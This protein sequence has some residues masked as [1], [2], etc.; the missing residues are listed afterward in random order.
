VKKTIWVVLPIVII[1]VVLVA[2]FVSQRNS[3]SDQVAQL[4]SD[5]STLSRQLTEADMAVKTAQE[6]AESSRITM[7]EK[8]QEAEGKVQEAETKAQ[9]AEGKAQEAVEALSVMTTERDTLQANAETA[10]AQLTAGI[11][12]V[13]D[14]L[15]VLGGVAKEEE[16]ELAAELEST[17]AALETATAELDALKAQAEEANAQANAKLAS[18]AEEIATLQETLN[19]VTANRDELLAAAESAAA[20]TAE[21][22]TLQAALVS[23]TAERDELQQAAEGAK[24]TKAAVVI[25]DKKDEIVKE[26]ENVA[27]FR[28]D[29]L[30]LDPG[31]YTITF[32]IYNAAGEEAARYA[33]PYAAEA[34]GEEVPAEAAAEAEPIVEEAPTE[35]AA[36][37]EPAGEE[38]PAET[39]EEAEPAAEND[40]A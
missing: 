12:Q 35:A 31:L 1:A 23:L 39:P 5:K 18:Q 22:E 16:N 38:A 25:T 24:I 26:F 30:E 20:Q 32:V 28:L 34:A 15:D 19:A 37:A 36:E 29:Q 4:E 27:D 7:E 3:L 14:A 11:K 6:L 21:M 2:V 9:E 40:A 17:K 8:V 10:S 33:F 13:Q